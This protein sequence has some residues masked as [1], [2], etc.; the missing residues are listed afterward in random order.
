MNVV[1]GV[2]KSNAKLEITT[3]VVSVEVGGVE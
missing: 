3:P 2:G 1:C